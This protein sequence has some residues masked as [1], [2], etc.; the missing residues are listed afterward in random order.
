MKLQE[1]EN[2]SILI[3]GFAREGMA[4]FAF[5]KKNLPE[6]KITITDTRSLEEL[7]KEARLLINTHAPELLLQEK[8]LTGLEKFEVIIKIPSLSY[9]DP[10]IQKAQE[11]G[12]KITSSTNIFYANTTAEIIAITGSKGKSTTSTLIYQILKNAGK[13]VELIGNI[14]EPAIAYL[15][16]ETKDQLY[17]FEMSSYQLEDFEYAPHIGV[18]VSFFPDHIDHH[19]N[20]EEYFK[21]KSNIATHMKSNDIFVYNA[22]SEKIAAFADTLGCLKAPFNDENKSVIKEDGLYYKGEKV[23][24][25]QN[26]QLIGKH[27]LENILGVI[28]AVK[29]YDISNEIIETAVSQFTGLEHRLEEV[30]TFKG[31]TFYNDA[32][33]TTPESTIAAINAMPEKIGTIILGGLDRGYDFSEIAQVVLDRQISHVILL[34][35]SGKKIWEEIQQRGQNQNYPPSLERRG[36]GGGYL[37]THT[38]VTNMEECVKDAYKN[39]PKG[40]ICLL[41][42][43]SPSYSI[44]KNFEDKGTQFK[45]YIRV[46]Q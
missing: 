24:S 41:S 2:K 7:P 17:V 13:N 38:F 9:L 29:Q 44:F 35:D 19:G 1:L 37:P 27:N 30:R 26:V 14:G 40:T 46:N 10:R 3:I 11:N 39:T 18:F 32:I 42:C 34:P 36:L 22:A 4:T 8:Y 20:I 5:L 21:A 23:L 25:L 12:V 16:K 6:S 28:T 45:E 15:G 31:I 43:A 33:S